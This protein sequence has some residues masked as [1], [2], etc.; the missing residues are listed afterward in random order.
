MDGMELNELVLKELNGAITQVIKDKLGAYNSPLSKMIDQVVVENQDEIKGILREA[1]SEA[2]T[3]KE[4]RAEVKT[5][6]MHTLARSLM[7]DFKGEIEKQS[8][9][10][11]QQ[12][13]FRARVVMAI[14]KVIDQN[15]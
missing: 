4:F 5:A 9:A 2:V 6:F 14:E 7:N 13:D 8:N 1:I 3:Q 15:Q 12:A 11:R 10:L